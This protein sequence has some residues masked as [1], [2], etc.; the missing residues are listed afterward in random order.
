MWS[1]K[2]FGVRAQLR[3]K[4]S[5]AGAAF[6][7]DGKTLA[8]TIGSR[9]D[10]AWGGIR[11]WDLANDREKSFLKTPDRS[12]RPSDQIQSVV[13]FS[14]DGKTLATGG[15]YPAIQLW[16]VDTGRIRAEC[17]GHEGPV[18]SLAF[19]PDGLTVVSASFDGTIRFWDA[20]TGRR[21]HQPISNPGGPA[22]CLAISSDGKFLA[23]PTT[24]RT[25]SPQVH[26]DPPYPYLTTTATWIRVNRWRAE[27]TKSSILKGCRDTVLLLAFSPDSRILA[28]A[29]GAPNGEGEVKLW[30]MA[31]GKVLADLKGH[32]R[33]VRC[34]A[35]SPDGKIL[36]SA[37]GW[38]TGPGEIKLWNLNA[39]PAPVP[40]RP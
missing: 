18:R 12:T 3:E 14:P 8:L 31:T 19:H 1:Q 9:P 16:D 26:P 37:G 20:K 17:H 33:T 13:V 40:V 10:S 5:T 21:V 7:P 22:N 24:P 34:L 11:L 32:R 39:L 28:S 36:V 2:P 4:T 38:E 6:S 15:W 30:D 27:D 29:G 35:F 25:E 23:F